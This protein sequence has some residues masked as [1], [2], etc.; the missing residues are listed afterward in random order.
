MTHDT[1]QP[2]EAANAVI[3][4][5][6]GTPYGRA[7]VQPLPREGENGLFSQSWFPVGV[8]AQV[9]VDKV[10]GFPF[11]DGRI[12][13][14]R[15]RSG[16][17]SA[18]SAYCPHL[19]ADLAVGAVVDDTLRC[20]FHHWRYDFGGRCVATAIG[21]PPPPRA[22]LFRY[23]VQE[24]FGLIWV[25]NGETPLYELPDFPHPA[26]ELVFRTLALP[27][28]MPVDP[29]VLCCNTPDMQHI[30]ALHSVQFDTP[31]P[32]EQ[33]EW[34]PFSMLY[35]FRGYHKKGE[36]IDNRIGIFGTTLY[37]QTTVFQGRWFGFMTPFGMPRPGEAQTYMV[38]AAQ[39]DMGSA[40]EVERFLDFIVELETSVVT[41]DE[42]I[43]RT[44]RFAPA[45]LTKSDRTLSRFLDYLRTYP[46]AH[47]GRAFIR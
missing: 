30:K 14:V 6:G 31:D 17:L 3:P 38:V 23:P 5:I 19:G 34:T 36:P 40:E 10:V 20:A 13:V 46:R 41:E 24:K 2:V 12:V 28:L 44:V 27:Q 11:L 47:P 16:T 26:D 32:H 45:H 21:D 8:S 39:R 29:W 22:R 9:P 35:N 42:M 15:S 33:V 4:N 25:F 43:M 18:L 7:A 37:Y 1:S